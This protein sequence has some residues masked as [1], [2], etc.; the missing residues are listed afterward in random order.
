MSQSKTKHA[1]FGEFLT[2]L[3]SRADAATNETLEGLKQKM[4]KEKQE[5]LEKRLRNIYYLIENQVEALRD[6]RKAEDQ[7]KSQIK[8]FEEW[9]TK[10][11]NGEE[12]DESTIHTSCV[13][14]VCR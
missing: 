6:I 11:V 2:G 4:E 1:N 13:K 9:A 10:L 5:K 3:A 7:I 8:K 12:V 14:R